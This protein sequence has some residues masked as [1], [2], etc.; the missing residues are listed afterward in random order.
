M[1]PAILFAVFFA[2]VPVASAADPADGTYRIMTVGNMRNWTEVKERMVVTTGDAFDDTTRFVLTKQQDGTFTIKVKASGLLLHEDGGGDKLLSTRYQPDDVYTR[3][4]FEQQPD[5]SYRIK[6]VGSKR[7][8]RDKKDKDGG[9]LGTTDETDD[10]F[11]RFVLLLPDCKPHDKVKI[12]FVN[13]SNGPAELFRL[14]RYGEEVRHEQGVAFQKDENVEHELPI[15][16]RW[17]IR[18]SRTKDELWRFVTNRKDSYAMILG[19]AAKK[20]EPMKPDPMKP[21]VK[22]GHALVPD[23]YTRGKVDAENLLRKA[24]LKP[25]A[26][27][28]RE[29]ETPI[30]LGR[31]QSQGIEKG[32]QVPIGTT[33]QFKYWTWKQPAGQNRVRVPWITNMSRWDAE[34][35]LMMAGLHPSGTPGSETTAPQRFDI[36]NAQEPKGHQNDSDPS[37]LAPGATVTYRYEYRAGDHPVGPYDVSSANPIPNIL[38]LVNADDS[39]DIAWT[40]RDGVSFYSNYSGANWGTAKHT[41]INEALR[42]LGGIARD[43][44]GTTF[45]ATTAL[46]NRWPA[47]TD[48]KTYRPN[49]A[50]MI[51]LPRNQPNQQPNLQFGQY[52]DMNQQGFSPPIFNPQ[53][54]DSALF[55][56]SRLAA[57]NGGLAFAFGMN[58]MDSH[59]TSNLIAVRA[60]KQDR[61]VYGV[62]SLYAGGGSQHSADVRL[63]HDG[64]DFVM[65]QVFEA[66]VGLSK[67]TD[68]GKK[69]SDQILIFRNEG[70]NRDGSSGH[71]RIGG[72]AKT[73]DGGYLVLIAHA[74]GGM[75]NYYPRDWH[76]AE[77]MPL[78]AVKVP[79]NFESTK[80]FDWV[81]PQYKIPDDVGKF[82]QRAI[83]TPPADRALI[84]PN[85]VDLKDGSYLVV[86]EDWNWKTSTYL[87]TFAVRINEKGEWKDQ[88]KMIQHRLHASNDAFLLPKSK[89]VAW[90]AGDTVN[91]ELVLNVMNAENY[92]VR[93]VRLSLPK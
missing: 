67:L 86:A 10:V 1:R 14:T 17:V 20:P 72:I 32:V 51:Y 39:L 69:W 28:G 13:L 22:P 90:V 78:Y 88:G 42:S 92:E 30:M 9:T 55:H 8:L 29:T 35:R 47:E 7:Y 36:I 85:L 52:L 23:L 2:F 21:E 16:F 27:P 64:T 91:N 77:D 82:D 65:A 84:R 12:K 50:K 75:G 73:A 63:I 26:V 24:G 41:L 81:K 31:V 46:E 25:E 61:M 93:T 40:R 37:Y 87:G 59:S 43:D 3:F 19:P 80:K 6:V 70:K 18:D 11:S 56:T 66:G 45:L 49:V 34:K 15:G 76:L 89:Q 68:G 79:G 5:Q 38:P 54:M 44:N 48:G 83:V 74:K 33:V 4:Q 57:G 60:I 58:N 53:N 62:P 71:T